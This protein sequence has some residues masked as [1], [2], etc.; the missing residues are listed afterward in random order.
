MSVSYSTDA[1][2]TASSAVLA[3][4]RPTHRAREAER[5]WMPAETVVVR[6]ERDLGG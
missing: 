1:T 4:T 6:V 2:W 3:M 5:R